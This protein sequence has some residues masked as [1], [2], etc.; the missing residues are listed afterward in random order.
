MQ[1]NIIQ[2]TTDSG[3]DIWAWVGNADQA[4]LLVRL[5]YTYYISI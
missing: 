3:N 4:I 5:A 1:Y 2:Y